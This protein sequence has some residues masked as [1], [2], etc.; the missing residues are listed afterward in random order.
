MWQEVPWA[1]TLSRA[2]QG[3][4]DIVPRHSLNLEREK[5]L[6][7]MLIGFENRS[8][9]F[10]LAPHLINIEPINSFEQLNNYSFGMLRGSFYSPS[11]ENIRDK[12]ATVY[13][14][15]IEQL[16]GMLLKGRIDVLPMQNLV[17]AEKAFNELQALPIKS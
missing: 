17:W 11:L 8:V 16:M 1:R 6:S 2:I 7:S 12:P 4:V 3:S 15:S 9:T 13:A 10:L 14:N 5:Y